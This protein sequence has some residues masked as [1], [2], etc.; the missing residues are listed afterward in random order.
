M[1][2]VIVSSFAG[3]FL[4]NCD[5]KNF[6]SK[7][8]GILKYSKDLPLVGDYVDL[9]VLS[10]GSARIL[11]ISK[12][13][14][15]LVR[16]KVANVDF[17]IIVS[18]VNYPKP[19]FLLID[20][21]IVNLLYSS[22]K[23][24]LIFNK[25]DYK[26]GMDRD[27][28]KYIYR[29][30]GCHFV[31]AIDDNK[32]D[33]ISKI[34]SDGISIFTGLSGVGKSTIINK[35]CNLNLKTGS[36]SEKL[37]RGKHTTRRS[38]LIEYEKEKFIVDTPGFQNVDLNLEI[39]EYNLKDYFYEFSDYGCKFSDCKH[40]NE[41]SCEVIKAVKENKISKSRYES[42]IKLLEQVGSRRRY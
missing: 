24:I 6:N 27:S 40:K 10:D 11:S 21:L 7:P 22:I 16:P 31:S 41:I 14:N 19:D 38:T 8:R 13:K 17:G 29:E 20:T 33:S 34:I 15:Q 30:Y 12:R 5:G 35:L 2:G 36:I 25:S 9:E 18:S 26:T 39:D 1:K 3:N 32:L 4:V 28:I 23:P 42:Y 37:R